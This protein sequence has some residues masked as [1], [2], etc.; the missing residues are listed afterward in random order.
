MVRMRGTVLV[1]RVAGVIDCET[2]GMVSGGGAGRVGVVTV[3]EMAGV[4]VVALVA[5]SEMVGM[6]GTE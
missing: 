3:G 6:W 5:V 4:G 2:Q 1:G